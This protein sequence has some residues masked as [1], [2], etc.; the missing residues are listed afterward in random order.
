MQ[1][2]TKKQV[3]EKVGFSKSYLMKLVALE[4]FPPPAKP[5]GRNGKC[6]W[7]L[8]VVEGWMATHFK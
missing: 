6:L 2:L 3:V 4:K 8:S 7:L 1:F 5:S